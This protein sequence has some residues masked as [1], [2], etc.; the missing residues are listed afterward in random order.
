MD[1]DG[2]A[3]P[4]H[5][6][7]GLARDEGL[8][9]L[10]VHVI[11]TP[12]E[13]NGCTAVVQATARTQE[14][15]FAAVGE[16]SAASTPP[17]WHPFLLTLAEVRAKARALRELTGLEHTVREELATPYLPAPVPVAP[18]SGS[19]GDRRPAPCPPGTR[20]A[21][22]A[23][24]GATGDS[25]R[26]HGLAEPASG[27]GAPLQ[28]PPPGAG[29]GRGAARAAR[30]EGNGAA[31]TPALRP[32]PTSTVSSPGGEVAGEANGADRETHPEDVTAPHPA[33]APGPAPSEPAPTRDEPDGEGI[34]KEMEAK[35]LKLAISIAALEGTDLSDAEARQKLDDFFLRAF[36]RPLNRA[37]RIEGQR[38]VQRL[39]SELSR[40]RAA[41]HDA[42]A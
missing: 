41:S 5:E 42:K 8:I 1:T 6:L 17:D 20:A 21:D 9:A 33:V 25:L 19:S 13:A 29:G 2:E 30:P 15:G 7:L 18:A 36:K 37:T 26:A 38:V 23:R 39:S 16:A 34:D 28:A 12:G 4:Y 11:Q 3:V 31:S 10:D 24:S 22:A 27:A 14:G 35:L 40:L 32:T